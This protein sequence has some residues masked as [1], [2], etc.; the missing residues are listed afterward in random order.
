MLKSI[1][2]RRSIRTFKEDD[3]PEDVVRKI[4]SAACQAPSGNNRQPRRFIVVRGPER[5]EMVCAMREAIERFKSQGEDTGSAEW[6]V[7]IV[8]RA[9]DRLRFQPERH[10]SVD[11]AVGRSIKRFRNS[12]TSNPLAQRSITC[13]LR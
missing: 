1:A 2:G 10:R 12:L 3:V 7:E 5:A 11:H 13:C 8:E 9:A 4:P 6:T